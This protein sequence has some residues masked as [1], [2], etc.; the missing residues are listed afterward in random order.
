MSTKWTVLEVSDRF[1]EATRT[2][3]RLPSVRV[4]GYFNSWPS[5]LRSLA[6]QLQEAKTPLKLGPPSAE[7]ISRMEECLEWIC[8]LEDETE[9]LIVWLRAENLPWKLICRRVGFSRTKAWQLYTMALLR[10]VT[11]LNVKRL[12]GLDVRT[13]KH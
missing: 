11:L 12:R 6:E 10:I 2:L 7:A 13:E 8:W 9:R 5:H 4:A 3:Q 1:E